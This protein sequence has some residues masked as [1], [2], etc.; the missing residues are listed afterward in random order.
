MGRREGAAD[1]V[2][3]WQIR[4]P[5]TQT[6]VAILIPRTA[7]ERMHV[8]IR[9]PMHSIQSSGVMKR[10]GGKGHLP[11]FGWLVSPGHSP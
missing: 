1:A 8:R 7:Y 5:T 11:F 9:D 10:R 4:N 3:G 6:A 2:L